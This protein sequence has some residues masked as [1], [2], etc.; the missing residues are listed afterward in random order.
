MA[1]GNKPT[2]DLNIITG[3]GKAAQF[4]RIAAL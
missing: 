3:E 2:H 4:T 1:A